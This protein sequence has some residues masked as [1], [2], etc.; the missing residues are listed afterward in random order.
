MYKITMENPEDYKRILKGSLWIFKNSLFILQEWDDIKP[1]NNMD[2]LR[3][4]FG[5]NYGFFISMEKH[6]KW[7]KR[8][9]NNLECF[10]KL[11]SM[12]CLTDPQL[13]KQKSR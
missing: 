7:D 10:V 5:F 12:K 9:E 13:S 11:S 4:P 3:H 8:L 1:M 6:H 2:L